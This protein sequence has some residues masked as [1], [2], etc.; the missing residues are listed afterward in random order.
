MGIV[1]STGGAREVVHLAVEAERAGWDGF[2]TWDGVDLGD[3]GTFEAWDP[4]GILSAAAVRTGRIRLGAMVFAL[5][6]RRPWVVAR[7]ALTVDHL[8]GGRLLLPVGLG[9]A[10]DRAVAGVEGEARTAR[11]RA[12]RLDEALAILDAAFSGETF[13]HRGVHHRVEGMRLVPRPV[14][15][16]RPPVWVVGA[17]PSERSLARTVRWDGVVVQGLRTLDEPPAEQVRQVVDWVGAHRDPAAGPFDVVAQG[18][19]PADPGAAAEHLAALEEAGA[20]WWVEAEWDPERAAPPL[21][22]ERVRRGPV[23]R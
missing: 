15:R 20:T 2:F 4:W 23:P 6:R 18:V 8:S 14:Q 10:E 19:L 3:L 22:L 1:A 12:E 5:P 17:W 16:P 13:D 7:Q 21:L 11:E 9:V